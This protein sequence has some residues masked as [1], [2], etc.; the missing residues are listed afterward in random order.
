MRNLGPLRP[1][2]D[3]SDFFSLTSGEFGGT[4]FTLVSASE[5]EDCRNTGALRH[6]PA[7]PTL[8]VRKPE[9]RSSLEEKPAAMEAARMLLGALSEPEPVAPSGLRS[10]NLCST[11]AAL[12]LD[13]ARE[14]VTGWGSA[15]SDRDM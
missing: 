14:E 8:H 6:H 10:L 13:E 7:L 11:P 12:S 2:P 1:H 9:G 3:D 15:G 5:S 4:R